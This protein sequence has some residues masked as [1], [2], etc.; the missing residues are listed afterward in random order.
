MSRR[1][2]C[3]RMSTAA[4][5]YAMLALVLVCTGHRVTAQNQGTAN[6]A[7][8]EHITLA[9]VSVIV[10]SLP[11]DTRYVRGTLESGV[12]YVVLSHDHPPK[13]ASIWL[14]IRTGSLNELDSQRGIAH[15]LE[16][17]AFNGSENFPP[18][19][20]IPFFEEL[21]LTFGRHQNAMTGFADTRYTL[22]LP[23]NS[24]EMFDKGLLFLS[25]VAGR[26]TLPAEEIEKERGVI[27][28]E[29]RT[30]L[31]AQQR[32][33]E[34]ILEDIS[35]G[36]RFG[37]RLPIGT[38]ER[39]LNMQR[40]DFAAYYKKWYVPENMTVIAVGD[41]NEQQMVD[42]ISRAFSGP[43]SPWPNRQTV[44][45]P[46]PLDPGIV[47]PEQSRS[48]VYTDP[49]LQRA[50]VMLAQVKDPKGAIVSEE[51][52]RQDLVRAVGTMTFNR[53]I[54]GM[55]SLGELKILNASV[56]SEDLFSALQWTL[57]EAS[58][59][60]DRWQD[61]LTSIATELQR[62][63]LHGFSQ[64]EIDD[65]VQ[66]IMAVAEAGVRNEPDMQAG[67]ILSML[68]AK[69]LI[70]EPIM[71]AQ[72]HLDL[73][74]ELLP[75][76]TADEIASAFRELY[77]FSTVDITL[78][79][80]ESTSK[81]A[82]DSVLELA[83][84]ALQSAPEPRIQQDRP[85]D[86]LPIKPAPGEIVG[87][88]ENH[89]ASH[90]T[91]F[92]LSNG[93]RVHYRFMD[94]EQ[95]RVIVRVGL[96]GGKIQED[97]ATHGLTESGALALQRPATERL[98]SVNVR[99]LLSGTTVRGRTFVGDDMVTL[100]TTASPV[101]IETALEFLHVLLTGAKVEQATFDNWKT[102]RGQMIDQ[103]EKDP[104]AMLSRTLFET[105]YPKD[106][107]RTKQLTRE[108]LASVTAD[109]AQEW[110]SALLHG[111]PLEISFVGNIPLDE[112]ERLA[113][114][115]LATLPPRER[116]ST[117]TL[118]TL[119]VL[120]APDWS[121][122]VVQ[123]VDTVTLQS[124]VVVGFF[125][126]DANNLLDSS[127]MDVASKIMTTRLTKR[128]REEL[129]LVYGMQASMAPSIAY[130]GYGVFIAFA[131]STEPSK[132]TLLADEV[133][134]MFNEFATN[135]PTAEEVSIA[136]TQ[137]ANI[138]NENES[139]P[140][141]WMGRISQIDYRGRALDD[142]MSEDEL[143]RGL[144]RE[145]VQDVFAKYHNASQ[146]IRIIIGPASEMTTSSDDNTTDGASDSTNR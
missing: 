59:E 31:G 60:P 104:Q 39:L 49:E 65:T 17:M 41:I 95:D 2:L 102:I 22:A 10:H 14:H 40:D 46:E 30:R 63:R 3:Q 6:N 123:P 79:I 89:Q 111:A 85:S 45:A 130:P 125:G 145:Q 119:R 8:D 77:D 28:E 61:T 13:R 36:S 1:T 44:K 58:C 47:V 29:K 21:G 107:V 25:D 75:T 16:H 103:T 135:G 64:R 129:Q 136:A 73:M 15:F 38:E 97:A 52:Y 12:S 42:A 66:S 91:S 18:G 139:Q 20:V 115:Y 62:A 127:A 86:L 141:Y 137:I 34:K 82:E 23:D 35:P 100:E 33:F 112:V 116:I 80:P 122:E 98:T 114:Q 69:V 72:Q 71:S 108:E 134:S 70:R 76:I 5:K 48:K 120:P 131:P 26:L 54:S 51:Q 27:L 94:T 37:Q 4:A 92:W 142:V 110:L 74:R 138:M 128:V 105:L 7:A 126:A 56:S 55:I 87:D 43:E 140:G 144:T 24:M 19:S 143:V 121:C 50:T 96:A 93:A 9:P 78:Q 101:D 109:R 11:E 146:P 117:S 83:T 124:V 99:D 113:T 84:T 118:S 106:D 57:V 81:P 53:R 68:T 67:A 133:Q 90:V 88:I 32:M 132:A